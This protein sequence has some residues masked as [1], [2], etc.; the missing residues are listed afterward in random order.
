[1]FSTGAII[2][3]S[4]IGQPATSVSGALGDGLIE[5]PSLSVGR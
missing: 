4:A 2:A 1:M 5:F 3:E